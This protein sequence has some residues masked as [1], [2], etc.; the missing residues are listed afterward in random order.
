MTSLGAPPYDAIAGES[1]VTEFCLFDCSTV[2]KVARDVSDHPSSSDVILPSSDVTQAN[3][4]FRWTSATVFRSNV[5]PFGS[6]F[7]PVIV[8]P[9][10]NVN[11]PFADS[12][13]IISNLTTSLTPTVSESSGPLAVD[14]SSSS[15]VGGQ[16]IRVGPVPSR[17]RSVSSHWLRVPDAFV[18]PSFPP[19]H[20]VVAGQSRVAPP[21][22]GN[23]V[24]GR[25]KSVEPTYFR[26]NAC[27]VRCSRLQRSV[28]GNDE[29]DEDEDRNGEENVRTN[30]VEL[31]YNVP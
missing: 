31:R 22:T 4:S 2:G 27:A 30:T 5:T 1:D 17:P 23:W 6:S 29:E 9:H 20:S 11:I 18:A 8:T 16:S 25:R 21:A 13:T 15:S 3:G 14:S 26:W 19:R 10:L 12:S 28:E 7:Q 24:G